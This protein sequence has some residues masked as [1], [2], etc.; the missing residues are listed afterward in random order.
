[1]ID[2]TKYATYTAASIREFVKQ[3]NKSVPLFF[4]GDDRETS[5]LSEYFE[6]RFDG[7]YDLQEGTASETTLYIEVNILVCNKRTESKVFRHQEM[8]GIAQQMLNSCIELRDLGF[9]DSTDQ[10]IGQY[11]LK[12]TIQVSNFGK[13]DDNV[14]VF[15]STVEAHYCVHLT[16][17]SHGSI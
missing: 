1:M 8:V 4:E 7:P 11:Q 16:E 13:I 6:V 5:K 9:T 3:R 14:D 12:S 2:L 15:Q 10:L 17:G